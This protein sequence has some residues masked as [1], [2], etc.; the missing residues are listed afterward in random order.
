MLTII[1]FLI[2]TMLISMISFGGFRENILMILL[3]I[4]LFGMMFFL[5]IYFV[6]VAGIFPHDIKTIVGS[7]S[8]FTT[9]LVAPVSLSLIAF[10]HNLC[11]FGVAYFM[12]LHGVKNNLFFRQLFQRKPQMHV[13]VLLPLLAILVLTCPPVMFQYFAYQYALQ[14][15]IH[16]IGYFLIVVYASLGIIFLVH[17]Y[18]LIVLSWYKKQICNHIISLVIFSPLY[19]LLAWFDPVVVYQDFLRV[20]VIMKPILPLN[21][22]WFFVFLLAI[23]IILL[24]IYQNYKR[25]KVDY[26]KSKLEMSIK[27]K[28][29]NAELTA[30]MLLH[31]LKNQLLAAKI[32]SKKMESALKNDSMTKEELLEIAEKILEINNNMS[33]KLSYLYRTITDVKTIFTVTTSEEL[34]EVIRSRVEKK[35]IHGVVRFE[36]ADGSVLVD[37]ELMSDAVYNIIS[38]ALDAVQNEPSPEIIV[39]LF[40]T[41]NHAVISINDNGCGMIP[42]IKNKIFMPFTSSKNTET[43]WG[44]GLCYARRIVKKHMGDVRFESELDKGT[45]FYVSLPRHLRGG[46]RV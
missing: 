32:L 4:C 18:R 22:I 42:A 46:G 15:Q 43:N 39:R 40:Y 16:R 11:R 3:N 13:V 34:F 21:S 28:V 6:K 8:F 41:R 33:E 20:R 7:R 26:D 5:S 31:G 45:T 44:L 23:P 24:L 19:L 2:V 25:L 38:N 29:T 14:E 1:L 10:L 9:L 36:I 17:E 37:K 35:D 12:F 30:S 27:T